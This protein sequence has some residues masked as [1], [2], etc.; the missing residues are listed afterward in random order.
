M[1]R[2]S[3]KSRKANPSPGAENR[4]NL[5]KVKPAISGAG[6]GS[7]PGASLQKPVTNINVAGTN[8]QN[9]FDN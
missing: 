4:D 8:L 6:R 3:S 1:I 9:Y 7:S 2:P 5:Y